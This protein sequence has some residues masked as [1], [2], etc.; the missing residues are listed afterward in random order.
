MT[1]LEP[2]DQAPAFTLT[3]QD[4]G[5][6]SL[7]DFAGS[8]VVVYFYPRDDTPGCT[9][10]ACQFDDNLAAFETAG[11]PVLGVSPD[12]A[13]SH[14]AF[15]A[16][17]GLGLRLLSDPD[18]RIM[19]AYGAWGEKTLYGRTSTGIIRSTFLVDGRGRVARAWYHVR[20]DGHAAKVLAE[21]T[22]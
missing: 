8:Q 7:S 20:A 14:A 17:H 3:D 16:K 6:V 21:V 1:R 19:E 11:V 9:K 10:E 5:E 4:G 15:R 13:E 18:H 12:G 2:G 22:G